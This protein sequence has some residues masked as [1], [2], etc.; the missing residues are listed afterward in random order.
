MT[1]TE[2]VA[3]V[4]GSGGMRGIGRAIA[5]RFARDGY[6][7][8]L[9]DI[10]R[11]PEQLPPDEVRA[12]WQG[13][14]SV[15]AEIGAL[16]RRALPSYADITK[17][18]QVDRVVTDAVAKLGRIDILVN[19][20][21][22][23][24]GASEPVV[25]MDESEWDRIMGVNAKGTFLCSRAVAR[26]FLRE[27]V[28]GKIVNIS[29]SAGKRGSAKESAYC[30]SKFAIIGFTQSLA[31]EMA[32]SGI[33]VNAVCP[34]LVNSGRF[35]LR[36]KMGAEQEG[37]SLEEYEGRRIERRSRQVPLGKPATSD[38]IANMVAFLASAQADHITGQ[39]FNV[40]GGEFMH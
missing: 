5:L 20:A 19:N 17:A 2:R 16:G 24:I 15:A 31:M 25:E 7:V 9:M 22:A 28:R 36:E 40:N 35:S 14:E 13:I 21:R 33:T 23:I 34:G 26:Y 37:V 1:E 11:S 8:V 4:T 6:D 27:G 12:G 39:S 18:D 3:I 29:S 32:P 10:K 30:A 38:D